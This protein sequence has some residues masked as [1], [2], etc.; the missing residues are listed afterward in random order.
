VLPRGSDAEAALASAHRCA[1]GEDMLEGP[2]TALTD[3]RFFGLYQGIPALVYGPLAR[4]IHGFDEAVEIESIKK[5]TQALA[6]FITDW[7]GL[8]K[9]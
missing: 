1:F 6:L 3:A 8:E 5:I 9:I 4:D 2:I 7:C